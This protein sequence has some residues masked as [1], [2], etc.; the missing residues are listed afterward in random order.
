MA[1]PRRRA[2]ISVAEKTGL[3]K[4]KALTGNGWEIVSTSSTT[5]EFV[6]L[7]IPCTP[8]EE[9]TNFPEM[10]DGR[11]KTLHPYIFG[12]ILADRSK[13][14]HMD[15][16]AKHAIEK[17]DLVVVVPYDFQ[18]ERSIERIDIGGPALLRAAAKNHGS[19]IVLS[20]PR[21]YET[22]INTILEE[23]DLSLPFRQGLAARAFRLTAE[24]DLMVAQWM[25][26]EL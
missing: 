1:T 14:Q 26:N 8:V 18:S 22:V 19:V 10:L 24:F 3:E 25:E 16:I 12:G 7:G 13:P 15:D 4:F 21:E 6:K 23:G 11:V 17:F 2:L 5:A 20:N 9:V